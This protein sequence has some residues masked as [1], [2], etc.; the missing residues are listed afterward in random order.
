LELEAPRV[1]NLNTPAKDFV[2]K[3]WNRSFL[4]RIF[5][6]A[7]ISLESLRKSLKNGKGK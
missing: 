2:L 1:I 5:T 6:L 4:A 7:T 3:R